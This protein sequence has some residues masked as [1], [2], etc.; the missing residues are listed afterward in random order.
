MSDK[1]GIHLQEVRQTI[2]QYEQL[3]QSM[4]KRS[5]DVPPLT[6]RSQH[7]IRPV[8]VIALCSY[9]HNN[10]RSFFYF[11]YLTILILFFLFLLCCLG[12]R[13]GFQLF[14]NDYFG[15]LA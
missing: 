6:M 7:H 9:K 4:M 3:T 8:P 12:N 2:D 14:P 5:R 10:V 15:G 11:R 1:V 13:K